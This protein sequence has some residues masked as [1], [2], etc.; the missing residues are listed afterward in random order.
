MRPLDCEGVECSVDEDCYLGICYPICGDGE[1]C[2]DSDAVCES[3]VGRVPSCDDGLQSGA[4]T[5]VDCGGPVCPPCDDGEGGEE[6]D[7]CM[8]LS[9]PS[10][11]E[12]C[13]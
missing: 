3:D 8:T 13:S 12:S 7:D 2:D 11:D 1:D 10:P 4:Q 9:T 5:D 6:D